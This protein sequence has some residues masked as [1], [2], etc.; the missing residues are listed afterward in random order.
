[1]RKN[2]DLRVASLKNCLPS[3]KVCHTHPS[4]IAHGSVNPGMKWSLKEITQNGISIQKTYFTFASFNIRHFQVNKNGCSQLVRMY[5]LTWMYKLLYLKGR[6]SSMK[7]M[8]KR[9]QEV[10][11]PDLWFCPRSRESSVLRLEPVIS[12]VKWFTIQW[13]SKGYFS[14]RNLVRFWLWEQRSIVVMQVDKQ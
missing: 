14:W 13:P 7:F 2:D 3:S 6:V 10:Q 4:S 5:K 12:L 11:S 9:L 1:M 8:G